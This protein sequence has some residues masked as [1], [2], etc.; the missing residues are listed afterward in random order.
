M[1]NS[2]TWGLVVGKFAPYHRGHQYLISQASNAS[3]NLIILSYAN[4]DFGFSATRR[5]KAISRDFPNADVIACE[6]ADST[7]PTIAF[8]DF[9]V[10]PLPHNDDCDY[11]HRAYCADIIFDTFPNLKLDF[12]FTSETYGDGF[13]EYLTFRQ[14]STVKHV[15]IDV[16]RKKFPVSA[17]RIRNGELEW[18][19]WSLM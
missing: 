5:I 12:V 19:T 3:D 15:M 11:V 14:K 8:D 17:T 7:F 10:I 9:P 16:E 4:P 18:K 1:Q 6:D 2:K 13:A